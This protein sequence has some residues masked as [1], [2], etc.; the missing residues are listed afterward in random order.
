MWLRA[1]WLVLCAGI[2][3]FAIATSKGEAPK[4]FNIFISSMICGFAIDFCGIRIF[5]LWRYLRQPFLEDSYLFLVV[6]SWG[7]FGMAVSLL[8]EWIA[9]PKPVV[10]CILYLGFMSAQELSNLIIH[11]WEYTHVSKWWVIVGWI[12]LIAVFVVKG[13]L[14]PN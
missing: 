10:F 3:F 1:R 12:G 14:L 2:V 13:N 5:R 7:V 9:L 4:A 8:W 6:P 11:S